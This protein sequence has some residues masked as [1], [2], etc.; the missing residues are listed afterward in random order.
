MFSKI[1]SFTLYSINYKKYSVNVL[2][3]KNDLTKSNFNLV[4]NQSILNL[5]KNI[6]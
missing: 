2:F 5:F 4:L 3:L 1:D 6:F